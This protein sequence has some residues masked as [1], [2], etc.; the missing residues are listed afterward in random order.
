M[1]EPLLQVNNLKMYF[2]VRSGIFLRQAGWV[3]AVDDVSFNIYPG[4][5]LGLVGESGCGKSTIGKSIVRLLKPTGGSILFNGQN[6]A[7]LSQRKMRPLRPHIQMVFQDPAESLNQRQSIGQI[8]AEPF[9]IHRMGTPAERREWVR[10]LLDRVGLPDSAIDRFPF[11]FSGGQRQRIG[12]ARALSLNPAFIVADEPVSAL[13]VSIQAQIINLLAQLQRDLE[14]TVLFISHDL[15]VVRHITHRVMVMY[16]GS[17]VEVGP[18]EA[19]F[20]HPAHPYTQVLTKA[21]PKLDPLNRQRD[22]AIEGEPP[23]PIHTPT[24]CKFHPRCPYCTDK[25]R[26]EVPELKEIAPGHLCACHYPL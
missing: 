20:Q 4:E 2:P 7:T 14:L 11:E 24:G 3:K 19:I 16:L 1:P 23:S 25:C 8:V 13:D 17:N 15:R 18:T 12:I 26:S 9:V 21:A 10:G 6:I 5:T 22:Y